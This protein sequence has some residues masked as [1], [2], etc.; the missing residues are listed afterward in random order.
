MCL[1]RLP[2]ADS[3]ETKEHCTVYCFPT[4]PEGSLYSTSTSFEFKV[5]LECLQF[6]IL[7]VREI[8]KACTDLWT[9]F[10]LH[11]S[12]HRRPT[13]V[14]QHPPNAVLQWFIQH[15][16]KAYRHEDVLERPGLPG[17]GQRRGRGEVD[18]IL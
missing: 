17:G 6:Y 15:A 14:W 4:S 13:V 12:C 9:Y 3:V 11:F 7:I 16:S 1:G 18:D 8:Q 10:H 2:R 5:I